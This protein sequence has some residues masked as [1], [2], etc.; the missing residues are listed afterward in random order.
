MVGEQLNVDT[1]T[2]VLQYHV[3]SHEVDEYFHGYEKAKECFD[4]FV[5]WHGCAR[6][7]VDEQQL[8]DG[9]LIQ[10]DCLLSHGEFPW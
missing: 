4:N 1:S 10:E 8:K 7:Y 3:F 2:Q 5:K 6:L 9:T